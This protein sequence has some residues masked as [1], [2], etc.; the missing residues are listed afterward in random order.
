MDSPIILWASSRTQTYDDAGTPIISEVLPPAPLFRQSA[1][2]EEVTRHQLRYV[3]SL[4]SCC[5][6]AALPDTDLLYSARSHLIPYT[7]PRSHQEYDI[8]RDL[9]PSHGD[10]DSR[11]TDV[12]PRLWANIVQTFSNL[13]TSLRVYTIS[14]ADKHLPLLQRI[15]TT[16]EFSLLTVLDLAGCNHLTDET[17]LVLRDL[18]GLCALDASRTSLTS[19]AVGRLARTLRS[20][21]EDEKRDIEGGSA[22]DRRGPYSL[23]VL[24]LKSCRQ[25]GH[26]VFKHLRKFPLLSVIGEIQTTADHRTLLTGRLFRSSRYQLYPQ[27]LS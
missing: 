6:R 13:P 27:P 11:L 15:P 17:I 9:I 1:P 24:W 22:N 10:P 18:H 7:A 5:I 19:H 20:C 8:L 16:P 26:D 21:D 23:R 25:I 4:L 3:P 14:L 12:D 2:Y